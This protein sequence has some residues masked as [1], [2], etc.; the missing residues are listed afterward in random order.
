MHTDSRLVEPGG[1]FFALRGRTTDGHRFL[2]DAVT[3]G[4][5]G[6]VVER[7]GE[8]VGEVGVLQVP[9]AWA[10]VYD[11]ARRRLQEIQ[12]PTDAELRRSWPRTTGVSRRRAT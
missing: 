4:A 11:L 9:D 6:V 7:P 5:A 2:A 10:A 12:R 8:V 1:L 3:R